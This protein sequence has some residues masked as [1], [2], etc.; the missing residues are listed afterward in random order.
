[1]SGATP[2]DGSE[3]VFIPPVNSTTARIKIEAVGNIFFDISDVDFTVTTQPTFT[4]NPKFDFDGDGKSDVSVY[5]GGTWYVQRST[6]GFFGVQF[7]ISTDKT[8]AED[9][10]GD[11]KTDVAVF[12]DGTWYI[13]RSSD[14]AVSIIGWGSAGDIPVPG[15]YDGDNKADFAIY[16]GGVWY[17]L[18]TGNGSARIEQFGLA[19]DKPV[20]GDFDGDNKQDLAVFRNGIWY[21]QGSQQGFFAFQFGSAGDIPQ[22]ENYD[23]NPKPMPLFTA[24]AFGMCLVRRQVFPLCNGEIR[25]TFRRPPIMTATGKPISWFSVPAKAIGICSEANPVFPFST[26]V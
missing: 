26:L 16:R 24:T 1:M 5:R 6:A 18:N 10:D 22:P 7:G 8:V 13:I 21:I 11:G 17:I 12:R 3:T 14:N 15:D 20:T 23:G 9:Y 4:T 19:N 2:N 25:P